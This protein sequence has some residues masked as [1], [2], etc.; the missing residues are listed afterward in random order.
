MTPPARIAVFASGGGS[1]LQA[2]VDYLKERGAERAG[3]VVLVASDKPGA[4]A[5]ERARKAGIPSVVL[6][7]TR[8]PDGVDAMHALRQHR[9]DFIAL[10]GYLRL[11]PKEL[12]AEFPSRIV[13]VHPA[14]LPAFGGAGMYG[15]RV[16]RAVLHAGARVTGATVH[17]VDEEY[18]RGAILAQWPVPVLADD[19]VQTLAARVLKVEHVLYPRVVDAVA[20]R[21]WR[22]DSRPHAVPDSAA[23]SLMH[24]DEKRLV[25]DIEHAFGLATS[26]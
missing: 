2:I 18:D 12:V 1:N 22:F 23:F 15:D 25:Q 21:R 6:R 17:Y 4:G 20:S 5:L 9:V 24:W 19:S 3:D 14:L 7:T 11:L 10:A 13:N 26:Q 8:N 16:H